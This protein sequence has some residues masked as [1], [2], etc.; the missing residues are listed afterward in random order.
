MTNPTANVFGGVDTHKHVHHAAVLATTGELLS[1]AEFRA[2]HGGYEELLAWMNS[3]GSIE[4]VGVEGTGFYGAALTQFL[5]DN[6]RR[7]IEVNR[8]NPS[9]RR[10]DGKSDRLDAEQTARAVLGKTATAV[11]KAKTGVVEAIRVLRVTRASAVKARSQAFNALHGIVVGAPSPLRD[12][13]I[14]LTKRTLVNRCVRLRPTPTNSSDSQTT[15][16][17]CYSP[18]PKQLSVTWREDRLFIAFAYLAAITKCIEFTTGVLILPQRQTALVAKQVA[19]IDLF[20]GGRLR[21]GVG[22][23][24]NWVE[25][26]ALE[27]GAYFRRRGKRAEEQIALMRK[28]WTEP[29]VT[30]VDKDHR[31]RAGRAVSAAG[32][33]DPDL[34]RR[35]LRACVRSRRAHRRWLPV[36]RPYP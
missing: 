11:P 1:T 35:L 2:D 22:V 16:T 24:R 19:D 4:A 14:Q 20:S 32:A 3:H 15:Q 36:Q 30:H 33:V 25:F 28:L 8:P 34:A 6:G 7:V 5:L 29:V 27:V 18:P 12:E 10:A 9:A 23:G 17:D 26:D 31:G 21:L 13:L